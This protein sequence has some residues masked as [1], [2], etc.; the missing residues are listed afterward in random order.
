MPSRSWAKYLI[1]GVKSSR[2]TSFL[3]DHMIVEKKKNILYKIVTEE[4]QMSSMIK[5]E[6]KALFDLTAFN[7]L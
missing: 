6:G 4:T 3:I 1:L 7:I 5:V 2:R